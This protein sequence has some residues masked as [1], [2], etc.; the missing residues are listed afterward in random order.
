MKCLF[1][2]FHSLFRSQQEKRSSPV[3]RTCQIFILLASPSFDLFVESTSA[4]ECSHIF[5]LHSIN[6]PSLP[7]EYSAFV[8]VP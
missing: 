6:Q 1:C 2:G 7:V 3:D 8:K 4:L 5:H